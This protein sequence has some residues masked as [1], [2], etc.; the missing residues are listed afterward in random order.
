MM[1]RA[2]DGGFVEQLAH[3]R[4][5]GLLREAA[6]DQAE[7][8][9]A[10]GA[11]LADQAEKFVRVLHLAPALGQCGCVDV[12]VGLGRGLGAGGREGITLSASVNWLATSRKASRSVSGRANT[13]CTAIPCASK[14]CRL[15]EA[16]SSGRWPARRR[17][18]RHASG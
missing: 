18:S 11:G 10:L 16:G 1:E 3:D 9:L 7:G 6:F 13:L 2:V 15:S 14:N 17:K 8:L 12:R 5:V 4:Q